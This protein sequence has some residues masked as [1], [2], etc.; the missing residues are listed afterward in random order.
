VY[1]FARLVRRHRVG[2]AALVAVVTAV[3]G[4]AV[5][6]YVQYRQAQTERLAAERSRDQAAAEAARA[7]ATLEFLRTVFAQADPEQGKDR[8]R[9]VS[10]GEALDRA[11]EQLAQKKLD[12]SV[13]PAVHASLAETYMGLGEYKPADRE[14]NLALAAYESA[15]LD[16]DELLAQTL[17]LA[18]QVRHE[19]G[20]GDAALE[21][22]ARAIEAEKRVHGGEHTHVGYAMHVQAVGMREAGRLEEAVALHAQGIEIE[23]ALAKKTGTTEDLA[24]ALNQ[25]AVTLVVLGRYAEAEPR[26]REALAMDLK[27]FGP[28]HPEVA[29]DYHHLAWLANEIGRAHV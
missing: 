5:G 1:R 15:H 25:F 16:D 27:Q 21:A 10:I 28:K 18:S 26:Y 24:D 20:L 12:A 6:A 4:G 17:L 22:G 2:F 14:A 3:V 7:K 29:T 11:A 19:N 23:R 13:A 9:S 8:S